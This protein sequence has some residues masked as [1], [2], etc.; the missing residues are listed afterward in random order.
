MRQLRILVAVPYYYPAIGGVE[1]YSKAI[2]A[3]LRKKG[4]SVTVIT[5]R[6]PESLEVDKADDKKNLIIRLSPLLKLSNTPI[7]PF[8]YFQIKKIIKSIKPDVIH[9]HSPVPFFADMTILA[10]GKRIPVHMTYHAGS[11]KKG[12]SLSDSIIGFYEKHILPR[13]FR[14]VDKIG[15]VLPS[16][17]EQYVDTKE[18]IVFTPP[19]IDT[20]IYKPN[21]RIKRSTDIIFVGRI[22][23]TSNWKGLDILFRAIALV[24]EKKP[25]VTVRIVGSGD[26]VETYR[27]LA[28]ELSIEENINFITNKRGE[29]MVELYQAA[30]I[31]VLPS[32]T[33]AE[34]FGMVLAEAMACGVAPIGSRIGGIPN[35]IQHKENGLLVPPSDAKTLSVSILK[36]L[37]DAEYR[38]E[39][40][41]RA[42]LS[43]KEKFTLQ[44]MLEVNSRLLFAVAKKE[45]VHISAFYP[46]HLGGMEHAIRMLTMKL[47]E[48]GRKVRVV[49]SAIGGSK[50]NQAIPRSPFV[51]TRLRALVV[52]STPI[53]PRLLWVL[54]RQSPRSLFHVHIA[55]AGIP[56]T[57]FL[58]AKLKRIPLVLHLH[59]DVEASSVAGFLLP[60]YKKI[61]LGF[62]LRRA[63]A[64][65]VPT[66]TYR[67]MMTKRY[68]LKNTVHVL[69]AGIDEQYF[70]AENSKSNNNGV[71]TVLFVGRLA[72][73][74][75]VSL[76]IQAIQKVKHPIHFIIVGD[77][78]LRR[79]L[80]KE[81]GLNKTQKYTIT[82]AGRKSSEEL[83]GFYKQADALVLASNYESQSL[84]VLEA[85]AVGVP[86]VVANVSAVNEIVGEAGMLVDKAATAF[87]EAITF[88][89]ENPK[90]RLAYAEKG[91]ARAREFSWDTLTHKFEG[92]Y[93]NLEK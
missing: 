81:A 42:T 60:L 66:E 50:K 43:V 1:T 24:K 7:N 22:E 52:A 90:I 31:I 74:K 14:R 76:L 79:P 69:P 51:V 41:D 75:N 3:D 23:T 40:A 25:G 48:D 45:I 64:V 54:L 78:P 59:G 62:V 47:H 84:V 83:I 88:L 63:D 39:L 8:W 16:F 46:P 9:V 32:K 77:G 33:E 27:Q 53:M 37:E 29:Q 11:M 44:T 18:K 73:E 55:Q 13:V 4:H 67:R 68:R 65:I 82:F 5:T 86:V 15:A 36:L 58:A 20:D 6:L 2:V 80:E 49:T 87:T 89:I 26:A 12:T 93:D 28:Q 17:V 71:F 34:S 91:K 19:G 10:A 30:K 85:M 35:V 56:E 92:I 57:A 21:L 72:I 38:Q 61:F 70:L